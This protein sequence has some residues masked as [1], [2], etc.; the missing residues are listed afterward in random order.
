[1]NISTIRAR[2]AY[3]RAKARDFEAAHLLEDE[4]HRA[5]LRWISENST[6][7]IAKV[8]AAEALRSEE[9]VFNRECA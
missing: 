8:F 4:L 3:I 1:M 6:D 5:V 2:L 7:E 9:I